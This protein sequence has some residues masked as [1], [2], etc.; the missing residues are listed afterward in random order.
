MQ[1]LFT[2]ALLG[3]QCYICH[4]S[5]HATFQTD[6]VIGEVYSANYKV[7]N[8]S[9]FTIRGRLLITWYLIVLS[10]QNLLMLT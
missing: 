9:R 8:F 5:L 7:N 4:F 10:P 1:Q 2:N 6:D 3:K